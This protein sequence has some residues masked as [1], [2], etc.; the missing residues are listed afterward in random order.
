MLISILEE[1]K[2]GQN[3]SIYFTAYHSHM[4][5]YFSIDQLSGRKGKFYRIYLKEER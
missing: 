3:I 2:I 5:I 1:N 4:H